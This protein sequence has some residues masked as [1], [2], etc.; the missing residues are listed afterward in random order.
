MCII[1][2]GTL[3]NTFSFYIGVQIGT[4]NCFYCPHKD[5]SVVPWDSLSPDDQSFLWD[6]YLVCLLGFGLWARSCLVQL[7]SHDQRC[8][9]AL[10][11]CR[12]A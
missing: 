9:G 7:Q 5:A 12:A 10:Q 1:F 4:M 2:F 11:V 8:S 3:D 6:K